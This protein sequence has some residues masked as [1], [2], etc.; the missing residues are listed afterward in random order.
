MF[1]N[2]SNSIFIF[3]AFSFSDG[4]LFIAP[5]SCFKSSSISTRTLIRFF[6][7][8]YLFSALSLLPIELISSLSAL[9]PIPGPRISGHI[10]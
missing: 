6:P 1:Y 4:S 5:C 7:N 8:F 3:R 10:Y 2:F 9:V